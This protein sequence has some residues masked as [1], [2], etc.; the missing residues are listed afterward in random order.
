MRVI[1]IPV[2]LLFHCGSVIAQSGRARAV[3]TFNGRTVTIAEPE[4]DEDGYF[5]KGPASV[6]I[7]APPQKQCYTA[8]E[9]FG[10]DPR[11][12][13]VQLNNGRAAL[14]FS[15]ASGGVSGLVIHFALLRP[16]T[17][18]LLQ[19][20]FRSD[21]SVS[22]QSQTAFWTD[23]GI[24]DA[25]FFVTA[26]YIWGPDQAHS[27]PHRFLIS[28][29]VQRHSIDLEGDYF[30]LQDRYMT[31]RAYDWDADEDILG[32]EKPEILA[33]LLRIKLDQSTGRKPQ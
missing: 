23:A 31:V 7:E 3:A 24:S 18:N 1:V 10:R 28:A 30:Y 16:G 20:L 33:R 2:A 19:N 8:P 26:D 5:P 13:V 21:P 29:Y 14:F 25:P 6:C 22:N 12:E 9:D 11:V 27:S 15:A 17:G 32:G 4:T